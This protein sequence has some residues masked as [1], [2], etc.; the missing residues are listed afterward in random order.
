MKI[1][2]FSISRVVIFSFS[3][4]ADYSYEDIAVLK[5]Y[6]TMRNFLLLFLKVIIITIIEITVFKINMFYTEKKIM[7]KR[8]S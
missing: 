5:K 1:F 3:A 2:F 6:G 7:L 4:F 8:F